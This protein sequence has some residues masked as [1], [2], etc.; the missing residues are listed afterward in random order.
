[1]ILSELMFYHQ[2]NALSQAQKNVLEYK[3]F[4]KYQPLA[5]TLVADV[6]NS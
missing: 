4:G 6:T 5:Q 3:L 1:M 2:L